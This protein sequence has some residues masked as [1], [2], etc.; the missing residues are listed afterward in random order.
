M[1]PRSS[2]KAAARDS[3]P[4]GP[5][6]RPPSVEIL[7]DQHQQ[8]PI[9]RIETL[10]VDLQHAHGGVGGSTR[11][12]AGVLDLRVVAYAAQ[13]AI[14]DARRT[15]RAACDLVGAVVIAFDAQDTRRA[16]HNGREFVALIELQALYDAETIAQGRRQQP[17]ARGRPD[18][19]ERRQVE[20]DRA[21]GRAFAD[22]DVDLEILHGGVQ[23]LFHYRRQPM[24]L[25]DEQHIARLQVGE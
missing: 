3:T 17:G 9:E 12:G 15:A 5:P 13:Q 4:T 14:S 21:R 20:L 24:D 11:D 23:H 25:V 2:D 1:V 8:T 18:Q 6:S 7:D 22:H 10:R 16:A 19:S